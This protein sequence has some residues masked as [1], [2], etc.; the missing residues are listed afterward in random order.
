MINPDKLRQ[1]KQEIETE[2]K[3][4]LEFWTRHAVDRD[5]GGLIGRMK[6]DLTSE[7]DAPKGSFFMCAR[8]GHFQ[9]PIGLIPGLNIWK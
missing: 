8:S 9:Q 3:E 1:W 2:L 6:N 4:I 5:H 7:K